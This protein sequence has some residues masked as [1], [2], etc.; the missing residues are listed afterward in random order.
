[1]WTGLRSRLRN[2]AGEEVSSA[3]LASSAI[4]FE[5]WMLTSRSLIPDHDHIRDFSSSLTSKLGV[6]G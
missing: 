2:L 6:I 4:G 5:E 3:M 1:M